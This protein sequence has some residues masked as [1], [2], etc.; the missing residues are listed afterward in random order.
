MV[1]WG[2]LDEQA[3]EFATIVQGLHERCEAVKFAF[4]TGPKV[5]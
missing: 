3:S 4:D 5:R 1:A 2:K